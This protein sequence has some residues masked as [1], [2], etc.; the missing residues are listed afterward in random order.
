MLAVIQKERALR[1]RVVESR[2]R[3]I[4]IDFI[5]CRSRLTS[6][7][8]EDKAGYT[9]CLTIGIHL[10]IKFGAADLQTI[11]HIPCSGPISLVSSVVGE[12]ET[13]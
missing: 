12:R 4:G 2:A 3:R 13:A 6:Q 8:P 9:V 11:V 7:V 1:A 10:V 5:I